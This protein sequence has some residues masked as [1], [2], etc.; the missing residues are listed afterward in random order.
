MSTEAHDTRY[1]KI[2]NKARMTVRGLSLSGI[3]TSQIPLVGT[4]K[5]HGMHMDLLIRGSSIQYQSRNLIIQLDRFKDA[6][7]F[8]TFMN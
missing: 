2:T 5:L 8:P 6:Y 3:M 4:A 1:P 7:G